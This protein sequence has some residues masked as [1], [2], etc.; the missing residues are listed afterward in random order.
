MAKR[1]KSARKAAPRRMNAARPARRK[2]TRRR[3]RRMNAAPG[4]GSVLLDV[5]SIMAGAIVAE[6]VKPQLSKVV[7]DP[8][9]RDLL[10][11]GGGVAGAIFIPNRMAKMAAVGMGVNGGLSVA[12]PM[13]RGA[14]VNVPTL[15]GSRRLSPD[16][17]RAIVAKLREASK[18][19][20]VNSSDLVP[21]LNGQDVPVL[22]GRDYNGGMVW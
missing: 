13:L 7:K 14:G 20:R 8:K 10:V 4:V 2:S 22:N 11:L 9:V 19:Y 1:K 18:G 16:E 5:G 15:N 3:A 6:M 21:T 12:A 17:H